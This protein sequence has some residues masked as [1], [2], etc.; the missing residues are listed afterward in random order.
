M[1]A[2]D[3]IFAWE[4]ITGAWIDAQGETIRDGETEYRRADLPPTK[5]EAL[6]CPEVQAL[7]G[8]LYQAVTTRA[9]DD[10]E[11]HIDARTALAAFG[12]GER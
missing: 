12:K 3:R 8:L 2:P 5:S 6:R 10:M 7:V 11:W 1:N 4:N 9:S